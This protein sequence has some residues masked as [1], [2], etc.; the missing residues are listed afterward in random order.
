MS[1]IPRRASSFAQ[2]I[3]R[4]TASPVGM[5]MAGYAASE[6]I[7]AMLLL[8]SGPNPW[9]TLPAMVSVKAG[10]GDN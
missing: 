3:M 4:R 8:S 7:K 9:N 10:I 5:K 1:R 2:R 6:P